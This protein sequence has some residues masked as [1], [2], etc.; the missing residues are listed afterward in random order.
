[1][2]Q[3]L[4]T[5]YFISHKVNLDWYLKSETEQVSRRSQARH[6]F[7]VFAYAIFRVHVD[8]FFWQTCSDAIHINHSSWAQVIEKICFWAIS[9]RVSLCDF[10]SMIMIIEGTARSAA[11]CA[12]NDHDRAFSGSRVLKS[13]RIPPIPRSCSKIASAGFVFTTLLWMK[14][15]L[16][17]WFV[18]SRSLSFLT[19]SLHSVDT[20]RTHGNVY[21]TWI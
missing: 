10:P 7:K 14:T 13:N 2:G 6:R 3:V 15:P 18:M 1:M 4:V 5:V 20:G 21:G 17:A 12:F 16:Y 19:G 11:W 8:V 9:S